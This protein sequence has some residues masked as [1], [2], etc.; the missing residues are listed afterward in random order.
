[1]NTVDVTENLTETANKIVDFEHHPLN[2]LSVL[3][4]DFTTMS[5]H[6][7]GHD[8]DYMIHLGGYVTVLKH[9]DHK[10]RLRKSQPVIL[11]TF[12]SPEDAIAWVQTNV[13]SA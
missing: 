10:R 4:T 1:M 7:N 2:D 12:A 6:V 5:M 13:K 8:V 9:S 3:M 11:G